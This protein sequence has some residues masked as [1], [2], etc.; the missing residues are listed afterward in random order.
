MLRNQVP[1]YQAQ[2]NLDQ[3]FSQ[4]KFYFY[5]GSV[6]KASPNGKLSSAAV[7]LFSAAYGL[8]EYNR[9]DH[10]EL[11]SKVA[12][13]YRCSKRAV[14]ALLYGS[15]YK[16]EVNILRL[17]VTGYQAQTDFTQD[18]SLLSFYHFDGNK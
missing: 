4:L 1:G 3:D 6:Q 2:R 16:Q 15:S 18:F 7:I 9:V 12:E 17:Q 13:V 14:Q 11:I 5:D 10:M 8:S